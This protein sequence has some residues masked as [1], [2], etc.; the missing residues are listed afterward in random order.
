MS[1]PTSQPRGPVVLRYADDW[2]EL[3]AQLD[4]D[5]AAGLAPSRI[6]DAFAAWFDDGTFTEVGTLV[7]RASTSYGGGDT[8]EDK[9]TDVAADAI[10]AGW[11]RRDGRL[12]F[13]S[14]DDPAL[15]SPV[16]GEAGAAKAARMREYA[17]AQ[18]APIVQVFGAERVEPNTFVG[19][20]FV[21]SGY[22]VDFDFEAAS[23]ERI[24]KIALV[25]HPIAE[26]AAI[27]AACCHLV[28][29]AGTGATIDGFGGEQALEAGF[30]DAVCEDL[31]TAINLVAG[32]FAH[33]PASCYEEPPQAE[34][35][36][37]AEGEAL[38]NAGWSVE[39]WPRWQTA[40][41]TR[42]GTVGGRA[43]GLLELDAGV[44][45][46]GPASTKAIRLAQF[47]A[48]FGLPLLFWHAGWEQPAQPTNAD[49]DANNRLCG[50]L[51]ACTLVEISGSAGGIQETFGIRPVWSV[52]MALEVRADASVPRA[53]VRHA[54]LGA[55]EQLTFK[56]RR[57][58][59]DPL[60]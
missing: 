14:A 15:G 26:Q 60:L 54:V 18:S 17:L 36:T 4:T 31:H 6:R 52:G 41:R 21:R 43:V 57:P 3:E 53:D 56:R 29:L 55:L 8:V 5:R 12:V 50:V 44:T 58:S 10:I 42:L 9:P 20:E 23:A 24:L 45:L 38:L 46:D 16:R 2:I 13:L 40:L 19:A 51:S 27:E 34:P 11:G 33:L 25:T 7:R 47:C 59:D 22:G 30:A 49:I 32:A 37:A 48:A 39:L 1:E 35:G 28:I